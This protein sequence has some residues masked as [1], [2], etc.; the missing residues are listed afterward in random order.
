MNSNYH[1]IISLAFSIG[2]VVIVQMF[3]TPLPVFRYLLPAFIG[4]LLVFTF[5][6]IYYL[7]VTDQSNPWAWVR[8]LLFM[9]GWFGLFFII[10]DGFWRGVF[11]LAGVPIIY[12]VELML[13][14]SG[15]QFLFNEV[16]LTAFSC[17]L[18][19]TAFSH[20]YYSVPGT[21]YLA[22]CFIVTSLMVRASFESVP[23]NAGQKWVSSLL[24]G[25]FVTELFWALSFLP[26]HYSALGLIL[27]N[28]FYFCWAL[29]Y[30]SL[31]DHLTARR[32]QY[33]LLL[34]FIFTVMILIV[35][36]WQ[37]II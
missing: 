18:S 35:T 29:L 13:G 37:I 31:F 30:H 22:A 27:F 21:V 33:H 15:Q 11:L 6:N 14:K 19:L 16:L 34:L 26:L 2:F 28:I 32:I 24:M 1:K 8:P 23:R 9:V 4:Y 5:Y 25:L 20:Y 12:L 3:A 17:F 7:R 10:P 36:P